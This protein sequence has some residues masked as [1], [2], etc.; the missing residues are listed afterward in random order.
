[1]A[2]SV[3]LRSG[4]SGRRRFL[5]RLSF[6]NEKRDTE[7]N[8]VKAMELLRKSR[9]AAGLGNAGVSSRNCIRKRRN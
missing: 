5:K 4:L 3:S 7:D 2:E 8:S 6:L 9:Y 1:V